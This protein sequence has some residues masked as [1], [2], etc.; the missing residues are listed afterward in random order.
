MP[1]AAK[2]VEGGPLYKYQ[3]FPADDITSQFIGLWGSMAVSENWLMGLEL[4]TNS[5]KDSD[6]K[7]NLKAGEVYIPRE[8]ISYISYNINYVFKSSLPVEPAFGI[9]AIYGTASL[10]NDDNDIFHGADARAGVYIPTLDF[11]KVYFGLGYTR[12]YGFQFRDRAD[13]DFNSPYALF[14]VVF[15][16]R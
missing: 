4:A 11:M 8:N 12:Y 15:G 13:Q 9:S 5:W 16:K 2:T 3:F 14:S 7:S 6:D 10:G 1:L